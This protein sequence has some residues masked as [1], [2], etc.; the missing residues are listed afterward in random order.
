MG[1]RL[2]MVGAGLSGAVLAREMARAGHAVTVLD[3]RPHVAGNCH[4]ARDAHTGIMV[5]VDGV[6]IFHTDDNAVW[7]YVRRFADF[8]PYRNRVKT[9]VAGQFFSLPLR[10]EYDDNDFAHR[11]QGIPR[12][13]YTAMV[14][15]I[16]DHPSISVRLET[17]FDPAAAAGRDHVFWSGPL[18][19][20]F[21]HRLGRLGYRTLDL[22]TFR[23]AGNWQGCAVMNHPDAE[24]PY[25]RI[26]EHRQCG[27]DDI[28]YHPI[29]LAQEKSLR[30]VYVGLAET[31]ANVTFVG[32]L[33]TYRYLDMDVTIRE[34]PDPAQAFLAARARGTPA[35]RFSGVPL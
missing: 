26:S 6:H 33:G 13:C 9:T 2:M 14:E 21:G 18:D 12:D 8:M 4:T 3:A 30:A 29:R 22:E 28:P 19:V 15:N 17:V 20:F 11:H 24:A 23:A 1:E 35:P 25:I 32:R 31:A 7:D 34:V 5:H 27:P 16:L 10:F